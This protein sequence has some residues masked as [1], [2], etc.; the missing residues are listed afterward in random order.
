MRRDFVDRSDVEA[1][2]NLRK[3]GEVERRFQRQKIEQKSFTNHRRPV[4]RGMEL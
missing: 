1:E 2:A 3:V 4:Y